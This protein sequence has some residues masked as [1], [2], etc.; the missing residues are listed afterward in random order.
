MLGDGEGSFILGHRMETGTGI[1][2]KSCVCLPEEP[3][4]DGVAEFTVE[5][6]VLS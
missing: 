5:S 4:M 6:S 2:F 3:Q 1:G